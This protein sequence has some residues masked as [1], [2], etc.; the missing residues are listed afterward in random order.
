MALL[1]KFSLNEDKALEFALRTIKEKKDS[2]SP[3]II[4]TPLEMGFNKY[5]EEKIL[6]KYPSA[7]ISGTVHRLIV[8]LI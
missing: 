2:T 8:Q 5:V 6:E 7:K 4:K 1:P 3:I